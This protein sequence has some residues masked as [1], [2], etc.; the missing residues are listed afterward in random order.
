MDDAELMT[1][2]EAGTL[3]SGTFGHREHLRLAWHHLDRFGRAEAERRLL[4]GLAAFA[5]RAGHP[6]KFN[7]QLSVTW[8][9][10]VAAVREAVGPETAFE[11]A[12]ARHPELLGRN[13]AR[14]RLACAGR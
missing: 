5:A 12:L 3:A 9:D 8:L 7:R 14:D 4:A 2:F 13:T 1:A 6:E 10:R 11:T